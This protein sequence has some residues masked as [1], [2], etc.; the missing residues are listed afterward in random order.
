MTNYQNAWGADFDIDLFVDSC[1][2]N[3]QDQMLGG[4][5]ANIKI[6]DMLNGYVNDI[7]DQ[8]NGGDYILGNDF[9]LYNVTTPLQNDR[10][11]FQ[12]SV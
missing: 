7:A 8:I 11:G 9:S 2:T 1:R 5:F 10:L 12:S 6:N 4:A 3:I